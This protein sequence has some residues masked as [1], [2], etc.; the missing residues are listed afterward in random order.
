M[1]AR[2]G[3][4]EMQVTHYNGTW[5]IVR[6]DL[7]PHTTYDTTD[8]GSV[9]VTRQGECAWVGARQ[10]DTRDSGFTF[11]RYELPDRDLT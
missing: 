5:F 11:R 9:M 4:R 2:Y 3:S 1:F 6:R 10:G 7:Y 8:H